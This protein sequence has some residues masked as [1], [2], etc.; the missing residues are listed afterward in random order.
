MGDA[1]NGE[2]TISVQALDHLVHKCVDARPE[3]LSAQVQIAGREDSIEVTLRMVL[4][5]DVRIPRLVEQVQAQVRQHL[6]DCGG[7]ARGE[8]AHHRGVHAGI[9]TRALPGLR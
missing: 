2:M 1:E 7:R 9:R 4:R 8:R 3:I 5:A 6:Q